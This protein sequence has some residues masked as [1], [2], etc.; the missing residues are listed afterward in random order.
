VRILSPILNRVIYPTL[1]HVGYFRSTSHLTVLTYHGVMPETYRPRDPRLDGHLHRADD[2]RRELKLLKKS[3]SI[4]LPEQFLDWS[5]GNGRLPKRAVLLTCDDGLVNAVVG[6][7][8]ILQDEQL[9]CLFFVTG[10]SLKKKLRMLWHEEL[11]LMLMDSQAREL[12]ICIDSVPF[13]F[14]LNNAAGKQSVWWQLVKGLSRLGGEQRA[15]AMAQ[16]RTELGLDGD[17]QSRYLADPVLRLR[18]A[19]LSHDHLHQLAQAGMTIG[20]HTLSHPLLSEQTP[21]MAQMELSQSRLALE[22]DLEK[23]VWAL[24]YPFGGPGAAGEREFRMAEIAGYQCAFL[25]YGG[26][27]R[28]DSCRF[29]LPRIHIPGDIRG[30]SFEAYASGFHSDFRTRLRSL[31]GSPRHDEW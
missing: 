6:M 19:V 22:A 28:K 24:A 12:Q 14:E 2:L 1:G 27:V 16:A 15:V 3:Y 10:D 8:P 25:N 11:Y 30:A 4:I 23:P 13:K 9:L 17:W 18:F 26:P 21:D 5:Q 31:A 7:L 29:A 20:A